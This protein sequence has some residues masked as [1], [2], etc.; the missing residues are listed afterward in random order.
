MFSPIKYHFYLLRLPIRV[1][2]KLM[3][4]SMRQIA[5]LVLICFGHLLIVFNSSARMYIYPYPFLYTFFHFYTG[6]LLR[7]YQCIHLNVVE[8]DS[9]YF[10][11]GFSIHEVYSLK[12]MELVFTKWSSFFL[13]VNFTPCLTTL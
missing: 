13:I 11:S 8:F 5:Y 7:Y 4:N 6:C 2:Y 3:G 10:I 1:I 9:S 12:L